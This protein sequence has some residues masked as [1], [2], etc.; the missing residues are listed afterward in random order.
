MG[1]KVGEEIPAFSLLVFLTFRCFQL[2]NRSHCC[3]YPQCHMCW[4]IAWLHLSS[5]SS[6]GSGTLKHIIVLLNCISVFP[7]LPAESVLITF[8]LR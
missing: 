8:M 2:E 5:T 1:G 3:G 4:D 6:D 7:K